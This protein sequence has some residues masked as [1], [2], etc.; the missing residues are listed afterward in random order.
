MNRKSRKRVLRHVGLSSAIAA[1]VLVSG[2]GV[3][4]AATH[5]S[6]PA[7]AL[8]A[9]GSKDAT[10]TAPAMRANESGIEGDV[11]ALTPSSITLVNF[12]GTL[13]TYAINSSTNVTVRRASDSSSNL[14][15]GE[16]VL[17]VVNPADSSA[18]GSIT[19]VPADRAGRM[20]TGP[21]LM[22]VGAFAVTAPVSENEIATPTRGAV[23]HN[24]SP[25]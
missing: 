4:S 25:K 2:V 18:A 19:I 16:N 5:P 17:V 8:M 14:S 22:G 10:A 1:T 3:A 6:R 12:D 24:R 15:L 23:R 9:R 13:L 20:G 7:N 11:T 21:G